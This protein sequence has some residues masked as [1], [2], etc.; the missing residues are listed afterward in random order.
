MSITVLEGRGE[1]ILHVGG[2]RCEMWSKD[3]GQTVFSND[4]H[5][6]IYS[7]SHALLKSDVSMPS[8]KDG[9]YVPST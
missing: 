5:T 9:V 7:V 4:G 6:N 3:A 1:C 2:M 8:L